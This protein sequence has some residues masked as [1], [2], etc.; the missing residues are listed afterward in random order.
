MTFLNENFVGIAGLGI[1]LAF[2][3]LIGL[4]RTGR[5]GWS[6]AGIACGLLFVGLLYREVR[7]VTTREEI[8]ATLLQIA[9][10]LETNDPP[11]VLAHIAASAPSL[12]AEAKKRLAAL[13]IHRA[14]VKSNLRITQT[15]GAPP[16]AATAKFNAVLVLSET[17]SGVQNL[18]SPWLFVVDFVREGEVWKV[19]RYERHD[20][21]GAEFDRGH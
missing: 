20:P 8:L 11:N 4:L 12:Q 21:R 6:Y 13:R 3:L 2:V 14:S 18:W 17:R 19:A 10:D 15:T 5:R 16:T 1:I 7:V 9:R